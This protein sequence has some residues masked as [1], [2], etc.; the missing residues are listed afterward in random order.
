MKTF[1]PQIDIKAQPLPESRRKPRRPK[2]NE[3]C[4]NLRQHLYELTG[5]DLTQ[6]EGINVLSAQA[7]LSEIG[8]DMSKWPT[9]KHFTSW[10]GLCPNNQIT[11]GKVMRSRTEK[12]NNRAARALRQAGGARRI[13]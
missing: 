12:N 6:I 3:P 4:F 2:G 5:V 11:G 1:E 13:K 10:L 8:T 7:I 9:V